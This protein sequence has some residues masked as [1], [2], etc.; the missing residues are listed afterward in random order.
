M[1]GQ[2]LVA[3]FTAVEKAGGK[4]ALTQTTAT[5]GSTLLRNRRVVLVRPTVDRLRGRVNS[6]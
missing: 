4:D 3:L 6:M 2:F 1:I 5:A